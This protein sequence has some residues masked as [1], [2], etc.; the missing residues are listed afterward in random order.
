MSEEAIKCAAN[1]AAPGAKIVRNDGDLLVYY[2]GFNLSKFVRFLAL[3]PVVVAQGWP[4]SLPPKREVQKLIED[5]IAPDLDTEKAFASHRRSW[6]VQCLQAL[7]TLAG[8]PAEQPPV[9]EEACGSEGCD[10]F[11]M[12]WA[13]FADEGRAGRAE[14]RQRARDGLSAD[15]FKEMLDEHEGELLGSRSPAAIGTK[16]QIAAQ[17]LLAMSD[18]VG[19]DTYGVSYALKINRARAEKAAESI[20]A[21]RSQPASGAPSDDR[22]WGIGCFDPEELWEAYLEELGDGEPSAQ[23]AIAF[24]V[25]RLSQPACDNKESRDE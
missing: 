10:F 15:D 23:G 5:F 17:V 4:A 11:D 1:E 2:S 7:L 9:R 21:L 3:Q 12:L 22:V 14:M 25:D 13:W 6:I 19:S 16:E 18:K 24:A 8:R 20:L